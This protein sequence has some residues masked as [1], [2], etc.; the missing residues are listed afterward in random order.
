MA[1]VISRCQKESV[2]TGQS[3]LTLACWKKKPEATP[4]AFVTSIGLADLLSDRLA[5]REQVQIVRA[6][7]L[8]VGARHIESA[9]RMRPDNGACALAVDVEVADVEVPER[10]LDLV[11]G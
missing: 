6:A 10:A 4:P 11:A 1:H 3:E 8:G 7:G 5:L 9:K 2:E